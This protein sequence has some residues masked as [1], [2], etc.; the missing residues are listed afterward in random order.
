M[1]I[2]IGEAISRLRY[3][4]QVSQEELAASI[5]VSPETIISWESGMSSPAIEY[6][7]DIAMFFGVSVD[8]LLGVGGEARELR[9]DRVY[10]FIRYLNEKGYQPYAIDIL[11]DAY[12]EFSDDLIIGYSLTLALCSGMWKSEPNFYDLSYAKQILRNILRRLNDTQL[13]TECESLYGFLCEKY[14]SVY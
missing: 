13:R 9:R 11:R 2:E 14:P 8:K 3:T 4:R 6:L 10:L 1:R 12:E 5:G 7:P